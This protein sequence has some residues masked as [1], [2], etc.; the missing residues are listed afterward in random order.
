MSSKKWSESASFFG[1]QLGPKT[2]SAL[3]CVA[4]RA[5]RSLRN[6]VDFRPAAASIE[7]GVSIGRMTRATHQDYV[8]YLDSPEWWAQRRRALTR[9]D[10]QCEQCGLHDD[11]LD[12]HHRSYLRLGHELPEDLEV[13][14]GAC[15]ANAHAPR[16]RALLMRELLGQARLFDRWDDPSPVIRKLAA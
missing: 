13:L 1:S 5:L 6:G 15:H 9:A 4:L 10:D 8:E 16:N 11:S 7:T 3:H 14:C 2:S 12:V